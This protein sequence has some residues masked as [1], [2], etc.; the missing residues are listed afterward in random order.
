MLALPRRVA[1]A[2]V[3]GGAALVLLAL[4]LAGRDVRG[5]QR[6]EALAVVPLAS[7]G[8]FPAPPDSFQEPTVWAGQG[9]DKAWA[10]EDAAL[11]AF[12]MQ[13]WRRKVLDEQVDEQRSRW[14]LQ[15]EA[16]YWDGAAARRQGGSKV[17]LAMPSLRATG[18]GAPKQMLMYGHV[19]L[20]A[21]SFSFK[22]ESGEPQ[23]ADGC[24]F[25]DKV[26]T[27][28][29]WDQLCLTHCGE[30]D[31]M[32][33]DASRG[34]RQAISLAQRAVRGSRSFSPTQGQQLFSIMERSP[35]GH[36]SGANDDPFLN[37]NPPLNPAVSSDGHYGEWDPH[38][39]HD[40]PIYKKSGLQMLADGS[41]LRRPSTAAG[42]MLSE[43]ERQ[44][45]RQQQAQDPWNAGGSAEEKR[46]YYELR[47]QRYARGET[48]AGM[49]P[50]DEPYP[51][52]A[53]WGQPRV[54]APYL[55][56]HTTLLAQERPPHSPHHQLTRR[57]YERALKEHGMVW[58]GIP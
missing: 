10:E 37:L 47:K 28:D 36:G 45:Q 6:T 12:N 51:L 33:K 35:P 42:S 23:C 15:N 26:F 19:E 11:H 29:G 58:T 57:E 22:K 40:P 38:S 16:A 14:D 30:I 1:L 44:R 34:Q 7:L 25:Q 32:L 56:A 43:V 41:R 20:P 13:R 31:A 18:E 24:A 17:P 54:H 21:E 49:F 3:G 2:S 53:D 55:R 9:G 46:K 5:R 50:K 39:D 48:S 52:D 8:G 4:A 27:V